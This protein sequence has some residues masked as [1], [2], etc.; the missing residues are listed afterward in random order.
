M[1]PIIIRSQLAGDVTGWGISMNAL[2]I[3]HLG[4]GRMMFDG[5]AL[6]FITPPPQIFYVADN[7]GFS[8][9]VMWQG[10][11][12]PKIQIPHIKSSA[13]CILPPKNQCN[14][15]VVHGITTS[16]IFYVA[17]NKGR[18][19]GWCDRVRDIHGKRHSHFPGWGF[20]NPPSTFDT[21]LRTYRRTNRVYEH[22]G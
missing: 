21:I 5:I 3:A 4:I 12:Y 19:G 14:V 8:W 10:E 9:R 17:D 2:R 15:P 11:G 1:L 6:C 16:K 20:T 13:I 7:K 18:A 22:T